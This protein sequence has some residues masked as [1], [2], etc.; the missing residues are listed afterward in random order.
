MEDNKT[1]VTNLDVTESWVDDNSIS[2]GY[3]DEVVAYDYAKYN[4]MTT[5]NYAQIETDLSEYE[6]M[7]F[8][9][10]QAGEGLKLYHSQP[11]LAEFTGDKQFILY[12]D[13]GQDL[14]TVNLDNGDI[15]YGENYSPDEAAQMFWDSI[16]KVKVN[17]VNE[18]LTGEVEYYDS[19]TDELGNIIA[20]QETK[21]SEF[22]MSA[23]PGIAD[24]MPCDY[25]IVDD[26]ICKGEIS[27]EAVE[28]IQKAVQEHNYD[29][30]MKGL[31][32]G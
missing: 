4:Q 17:E 28:M 9:D 8:T 7:T 25:T 20:L 16:G 2:K 31:I 13:E 21:T 30:S 15:M 24:D 5:D 23:P 6:G 22:K 19:V 27:D 18:Q 26:K 14:V 32:D 1:L 11:I 10:V 29:E 3:I 12:N